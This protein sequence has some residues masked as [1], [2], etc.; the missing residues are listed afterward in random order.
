MRRCNLQVGPVLSVLLQRLRGVSGGANSG[1]DDPVGSTRLPRQYH[2]KTGESPV[3]PPVTPVPPAKW[4]PECGNKIA[5]D[6]QVMPLS[7]DTAAC[8]SPEESASRM[9]ER[10]RGVQRPDGASTQDADDDRS[11]LSQQNQASQAEGLGQ[12]RTANPVGGFTFWDQA[13]PPLIAARLF[14]P[15]LIGC[16]IV[17]DR[18]TRPLPLFA[19]QC[20]L[21][22]RLCLCSFPRFLCRSFFASSSTPG[23]N[24]KVLTFGTI[25]DFFCH[26]FRYGAP[27]RPDVR[28]IPRIA[29][30]RRDLLT[31]ATTTLCYLSAR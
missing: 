12:N 24:Q 31:S 6:M 17:S 15:R 28:R 1:T 16:R 22:F 14:R 21:S 30:F 7:D 26:P 29:V 18:S 27:A 23:P 3:V 10:A 11:G 5:N 9:P 8:T 25:L 19:S 13:R 20:C 2:L 4:I